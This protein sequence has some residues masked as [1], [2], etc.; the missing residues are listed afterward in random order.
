MTYNTPEE[1]I[2]KTGR[3]ATLSDL[4]AAGFE[5]GYFHGRRV[6]GEPKKVYTGKQ[7]REAIG[8][9]KKLSAKGGLSAILV[10]E[11]RQFMEICGKPALIGSRA[12]GIARCNNTDKFDRQF[13]TAMATRRALLHMADNYREQAEQ[14]LARARQLEEL[15]GGPAV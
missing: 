12:L 7:M 8:G 14:F 10:Q 2:V 4:E 5:V 3:V 9:G 15:A 11:P 6:K 13:G 1:R